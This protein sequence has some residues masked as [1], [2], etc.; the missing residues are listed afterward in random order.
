[1][2]SLVT[3]KRP[4]QPP[5]AK[6]FFAKITTPLCTQ[7]P[8]LCVC[9]SLLISTTNFALATSNIRII[10]PYGVGGGSDQHS[11]AMA[12][13]LEHTSALKVYVTNR[14]ADGGAEA[15]KIFFSQTPDGT[16]VLQAT[17]NLVSNYVAGYIRYH[18]TKDLIPIGITQ[19]TYNQIYVRSDDT[20]FSNW[21]SFVTFAQS[22]A[23]ITVANVGNTGSMEYLML[24]QLQQ[25]L[26]LSI[27]QESYDR[28]QLRYQA[29]LNKSVDALIE[30]PGDVKFLLEKYQI[31]PII[32]L[33]KQRP[34][35]FLDVPALGDMKLAITPMFRFRGF[36]L[37]ATTPPKIVK[38]ITQQFQK[39]WA[40][41]S[42]QQF[43]K[44]NY[45]DLIPHYMEHHS[46]VQFIDQLIIQYQ[47][48]TQ[49][50]P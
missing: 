30:Q 8:Y 47:Q 16:N 6:A 19:L 23:P 29:L 38:R 24:N 15:F 37:H 35:G 43:N 12:Q 34:S 39:A 44:D 50:T 2:L 7:Y 18:P 20:R 26:H 27:F 21:E 5:Q 1:M 14:P 25:K 32:S 3:L 31:K 9:L 36:F 49:K 45:M 48:K 42:F 10:V 40:S 46:A 33:V 13:A 17:D 22:H 41:P 28:P 4:T 11:R